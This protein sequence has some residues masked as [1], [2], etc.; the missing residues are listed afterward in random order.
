MVM[1]DLEGLGWLVGTLGGGVG[2]GCSFSWD[3]QWWVVGGVVI[4]FVLVFA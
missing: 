2:D 3:R 1:G 4:G